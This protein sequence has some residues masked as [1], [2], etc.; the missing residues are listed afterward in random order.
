MPQSRK[1][2]FVMGARGHCPRCAAKNLFQSPY[3]LYPKCPSCGLPIE[4][5]DGW[6]LGAIP[7]NYA[8]T[9]LCWVLPVGILFMTG[10]LTLKSAL[11]IAG[12]GC[13]VLPFLTYRLSKRLWLGIYF[14]VLPHELD[15]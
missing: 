10:V 5:E 2:I 4:K 3:R 14:A 7:L 1:S 12:I 8:I 6:G 13:L 15:E 9:G 11:V